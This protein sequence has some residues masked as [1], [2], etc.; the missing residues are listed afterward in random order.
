[1]LLCGIIYGFWIGSAIVAVGTILGEVACYLYVAIPFR[2]YSN[3]FTYYRIPPNSVFGYWFRGAM[4]KFE[5]KN[6]EYAC[7]A[8]IFR[9]G[10]FKAILLAR[11]SLLPPHCTP[12]VT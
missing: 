4:L 5:N 9:T 10:G 12:P 6:L 11:F 2:K 1:M 8:E 7:Y 3:I